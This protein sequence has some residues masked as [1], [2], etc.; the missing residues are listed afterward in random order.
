M[1]TVQ[2]H[3]G[4]RLSGPFS[5]AEMDHQAA[6]RHIRRTCR[7]LRILC[8]SH[9]LTDAQTSKAV[10]ILRGKLEQDG[11]KDRASIKDPLGRSQLNQHS[12]DACYSAMREISAAVG[13][14][15]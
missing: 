1:R 12:M 4:E 3:N 13:D 10:A 11:P 6:Q 2:W 8:A 5:D 14:V 15:K 9:G 7:R